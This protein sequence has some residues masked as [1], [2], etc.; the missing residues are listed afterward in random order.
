MIINSCQT[1]GPVVQRIPRKAQCVASTH[2][3]GLQYPS[4]HT[5]NR[6]ALHMWDSHGRAI[7][8]GLLVRLRIVERNKEGNCVI[9][10][11]R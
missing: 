8:P 7:S 9:L 11:C 4:L 1:E 6:E 5:R 10:Q 2:T 3:S